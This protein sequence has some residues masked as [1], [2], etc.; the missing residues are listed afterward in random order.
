MS[1]ID[2]Q[3]RTIEENLLVRIRCEA[4]SYIR[5][6]GYTAEPYSAKLGI[7]E[8]IRASEIKGLWR[9]WA[10]TLLGGVLW[11]DGYDVN[12]KDL[13]AATSTILGS[14]KQGSSSIKL[15]VDNT[16][17][18]E[19]D[20]TSISD[21]MN[22]A[23][24]ARLELLTES[25]KE[26][27]KFERYI[28]P[29]AT[30][31]ISLYKVPFKD[32]PHEQELFAIN[33]LILALLFSGVGSLINRGFGKLKVSIEKS[34]VDMKSIK[35]ILSNIYNSSNEEE[36]KKNLKELL[37]ASYSITKSIVNQL[38]KKNYNIKKRI[39]ENDL[40]LVPSIN[41]KTFRYDVAVKRRNVSLNEVL[42]CISD[43]SLKREWKSMKLFK[44][45]FKMLLRNQKNEVLKKGGEAYHTWILGLPRRGKFKEYNINKEYNTGYESKYDRRQSAISFSLIKLNDG[46]YAIIIY[47]FKTRDW[48]TAL[49][50]M[51][52][53]SCIYIKERSKDG[54]IKIK[55]V[56]DHKSKDLVDIL[57]AEPNVKL[58]SEIF[59]DAWQT[60]TRIVR[61]DEGI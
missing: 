3:Q 40:P 59:D 30:F 47:G 6:G 54:K 60:V 19:Q 42:Q 13:D 36:I 50:H 16:S 38:I 41:E 56:K 7:Q 20:F 33:S 32:L 37:N 1:Y 17:I 15:V 31:R 51:K 26:W 25:K 5:V 10:R 55:G 14:E 27:E 57:K 34:S 61:R 49:K 45:P 24:I 23:K 9:W 21:L 18:S 22:N 4:I 58:L 39:E 46:R 29:G 11:E 52:H 43:A 48:I 44:R 53:F 12:L 35:E 2:I 28:K 8:L